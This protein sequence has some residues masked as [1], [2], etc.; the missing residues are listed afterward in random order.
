[1]GPSWCCAALILLL[2]TADGRGQTGTAVVFRDVA[3]EAG[4]DLVTYCGSLEKNHIQE[5]SGTGGAFFDYDGDGYLDLYIVNAWRIA[6][7]KV[8][9]KGANALYRNRGDG[10]FADVTGEA[11]VGDRGWGAGVCVG[12]FDNDGHPDLYVTNVGPNRL[13]RNRGDGTFADVTEAAGVGDPGTGT[14]A[15]FLD[16]DGD[17]DLD[18]YVANYVRST[19][20]EV[21]AAERS[22]MWRGV[23]NVLLGP[24]GLQGDADAFYRNNGDGT[25]TDVTASAGLSARVPFYGFGVCA[26]DYDGDGDPD[27]YVANDTNPN[28]LYRNNGDGTFREVG[29][30]MNAARS[31]GGMAQAGMGV[32]AGDFDNDGDFDLFVTNFSQD[33]STL[34]QNQGRYFEDITPKAGLWKPTYMSLSWGTAFFDY[35]NDGALDLFIANGHIYSQLDGVEDHAETYRQ[36]NQLF[37]NQGGRFVDVSDKAGPGMSLVQSSRGAVFGDYDNDG[38]VDVAVLNIDERPNLLRNDGGNSGHWLQVKTVGTRSNRM[39]IGAR[40]R[41]RSDSLVQVREIRSGSSY[42]SQNDMRAHFGLGERT[43]VD[44]VEV[45]WPTGTVDLLVDLPADRLIVVEEGRGR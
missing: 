2:L 41:V 15:A 28:F 42:L 33:Y 8:A 6:D 13:Y 38:D 45:R 5:A 9:S 7:R 14:G 31:K 44:T 22:R 21:L 24:R 26:T 25:F 30:S 3:P 34:Y 39:G 36:A 4:L 43:R 37:H 17:G 29:G 32:D 11:G 40:V 27:I 19:M 23:G 10:T 1:M 16:Y 20:E 18:L 35:D 12:D